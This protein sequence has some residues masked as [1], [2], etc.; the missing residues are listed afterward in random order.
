MA[1]GDFDDDVLPSGAGIIIPANNPRRLFLA[2][3]KMWDRIELAKR[4]TNLQQGKFGLTSEERL[5]LRSSARGSNLDGLTDEMAMRSTTKGERLDSEMGD[6][7]IL[8]V[9]TRGGDVRQPTSFAMIVNE[10]NRQGQNP[11]ALKQLEGLEEEVRKLVEAGQPVDDALQRRLNTARARGR[12]LL[13]RLEWDEDPDPDAPAGAKP[14]DTILNR[15]R[16]FATDETLK[17]QAQ[18]Q[19]W[20]E[21]LERLL[22]NPD[23]LRE[24]GIAYGGSVS[25]RWSKPFWARLDRG[26]N[27]VR[28]VRCGEAIWHHARNF[29]GRKLHEYDPFIAPPKEYLNEKITEYFD[30]LEKRN[31][32]LV[33]RL[34]E[35]MDDTKRPGLREHR[36]GRGKW[37]HYT[38]AEITELPTD[39]D[40]EKRQKV[41]NRDN[42]IRRWNLWWHLD[43]AM[44]YAYFSYIEEYKTSVLEHRKYL[45]DQHFRNRQFVINGRR[46]E[47]RQDRVNDQGVTE[48]GMSD[49]ELLQMWTDAE[50]TKNPNNSTD[51]GYLGY[52]VQMPPTYQYA[53]WKRL[54][55]KIRFADERDG[56]F[57]GQTEAER[58]F[59]YHLVQ[60][61]FTWWEHLPRVDNRGVVQYKWWTHPDH[62]SDTCNGCA[63]FDED[64]SKSMWVP[65]ENKWTRPDRVPEDWVYEEEMIWHPTRQAIQLLLKIMYTHNVGSHLADI[66][67]DLILGEGDAKTFRASYGGGGNERVSPYEWWWPGAPRSDTLDENNPV[68]VATY[69]NSGMVGRWFWLGPINDFI[70][71][72][73]ARPYN[74]IWLHHHLLVA[75]LNESLNELRDFLKTNR[76]Y[77]GVS[78]DDL[79]KLCAKLKDFDDTIVFPSSFKRR[80]D[81]DV[82]VEFDDLA[83]VLMP[84]SSIAGAADP[85]WFFRRPLFVPDQLA[86]VVAEYETAYQEWMIPGTH[87]FR[88]GMEFILTWPNGRKSTIKTFQPRWVTNELG[89]RVWDETFHQYIRAFWTCPQHLA[90]D[91]QQSQDLTRFETYLRGVVGRE[92][93]NFNFDG[94]RK[95]VN[96]HLSGLPLTNPVLDANGN[97]T[98]KRKPN[99]LGKLRV[100]AYEYADNLFMES[101]IMR[102]RDRGIKFGDITSYIMNGGF[103]GYGSRK[104]QFR[105]I[106]AAYEIPLKN[107]YFDNWKGIIEKHDLMHHA[108]I[109]GPGGAWSDALED[110][111][112]LLKSRGLNW[113][114]VYEVAQDLKAFGF[115]DLSNWVEEHKPHKSEEL[116]K[117]W[118]KHLNR[119]AMK[120]NSNG[121]ES[122]VADM[123]QEI[124]MATP[125]DPDKLLRWPTAAERQAL[126]TAA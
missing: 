79:S 40:E 4:D 114:F 14:P 126:Y 31:S 72:E 61:M 102:S 39:T 115:I 46:I 52:F 30:K 108:G 103:T 123:V 67:A 113:D 111:A 23:F 41:A 34:R 2:V 121:G 68:A 54:E 5:L 80:S 82:D 105:R 18:R 55:S 7:F 42:A 56:A 60:R 10:R 32:D 47:V 99:L 92:A 104:D 15:L 25:T 87:E 76:K 62:T 94:I 83:P 64:L 81:G 112:G 37:R 97:D 58:I 45:Q 116:E 120:V 26:F 29:N 124:I 93:N 9:P 117:T 71:T 16:H 24:M 6:G 74:G 106:M 86:K 65:G 43:Q 109:E 21:D 59:A 88:E 122:W 66:F 49:D 118:F 78:Q 50:V 3:R 73:R 110:L 91:F 8:L 125:C 101:V 33:V 11:Q 96:D 20:F 27:L 107:L 22:T 90:K 70:E 44:Q 35:D 75:E 57:D 98:G 13:Q 17:E 119:L 1:E 84:A 48:P 89:E 28:A 69:L 95:I 19:G 77:T 53:F 12:I 36:F 85:S 51:E 38:H 63:H 100:W